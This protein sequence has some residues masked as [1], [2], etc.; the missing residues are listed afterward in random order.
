MHFPTEVWAVFAQCDAPRTPA[1]IA[2]RIRLD[3]A[4]VL[5]ALRRLSNKHLIR[6]NE[7]DW[8]TYLASLGAPPAAV[9]AP[10]EI[11]TKAPITLPVPR[12]A[13]VAAVPMPSAP[14]PPTLQFAAPASVPSAAQPVEFT[15]D[16]PSAAIARRQ[17]AREVLT[18]QV[19]KPSTS[20]T[21]E[22]APVLAA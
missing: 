7:I 19:G 11:V 9:E 12:E 14:A 18:F 13:G 4:D 5:S 17:A 8:Q 22:A 10:A 2:R 16:N 3:A 6:K 21:C 1:E 15:L 20:S